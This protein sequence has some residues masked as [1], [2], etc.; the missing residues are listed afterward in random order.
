MVLTTP[1]FS[2]TGRNQCQLG[3]GVSWRKD[4][5][6]DKLILVLLISYHSSLSEE[7]TL[8]GAH[9]SCIIGVLSG[10]D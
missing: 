4:A 3:I 10:L 6:A 8:V 5:K 2:Y 7:T 1:I 9:W